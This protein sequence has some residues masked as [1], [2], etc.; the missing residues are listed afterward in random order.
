MPAFLLDACLAF[1]PQPLLAVL[2][3]PAQSCAIICRSSPMV[4][5]FFVSRCRSEAGRDTGGGRRRERGGLSCGGRC[6]RPLFRMA[7][8]ARP[9]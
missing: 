5:Y 8:G 7:R 6:S 1:A 4:S 3:D 2:D 9:G